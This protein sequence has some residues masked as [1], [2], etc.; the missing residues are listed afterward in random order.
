VKDTIMDMHR[1]RMIAWLG[2]VPIISLLALPFVA[3][4]ETAPTLHAERTPSYT[5]ELTIGSAEHMLSPMEAMTADTGE[6]MVT[7]GSMT[8]GMGM[9]TSMPTPTMDQ[10]RPVNHHLE[11]HITRND[12]GGVVNDV[13]PTIRITEKSTGE[14]RDLPQVI[15]MLGVQ[16][17]PSDFHYGQNVYLSDGTYAV[18]VMIGQDTAVFRDVLV[19][20]GTPLPDRA[21]GPNSSMPGSTDSVAPPGSMDSMSSTSSD[22]T[23]RDGRQFSGQPAATQAL[24]MAVWGDH[25]AQ[26][27][28][29]EHNASLEPG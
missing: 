17:D 19:T 18:A 11:V 25:A 26:E 7:G 5:L 9:G 24:F 22:P 3:S 2:W 10:G 23:A 8:M 21:M 6:V 29:T 4:A 1:R 27:W 20:A 13:T 15:G 14:S 12:T 16:A 28:V